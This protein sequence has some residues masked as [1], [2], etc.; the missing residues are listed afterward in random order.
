MKSSATI[1]AGVSVLLASLA[2]AGVVYFDLSIQDSAQQSI[3]LQNSAQTV[4]DQEATA[5]Q[6]RQLAKQMTPAHTALQATLASD[7]LSL[8][9]MIT[10]AGKDAGIILSVNNASADDSTASPV[11]DVSHIASVGFALEATGSFG[12]LLRAINLLEALPVP[13]NIKQADLDLVQ[14]AGAK[15]ASWHLLLHV[16]VLTASQISS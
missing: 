2:W 9:S 6:L 11:G 1:I 3:E 5:I 13:S 12:A 15:S 16:R 7:P 14:N 8:A 10:T 4:N